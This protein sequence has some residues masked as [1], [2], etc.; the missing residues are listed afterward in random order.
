MKHILSLFGFAYN[1]RLDVFEEETEH[2][3][4][5]KQVWAMLSP[6]DRRLL[7]LSFSLG[8]RRVRQW[9]FQWCFELTVAC[10]SFT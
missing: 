5:C 2:K 9:A 1:A 6:L 10:Y 7:T 4:K 3:G 8:L